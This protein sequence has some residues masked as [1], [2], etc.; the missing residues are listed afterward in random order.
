MTDA[1]GD[2]DDTETGTTA[3]RP[4][5]LDLTRLA[6]LGGD[7]EIS[8]MRLL[9]PCGAVLAEAEPAPKLTS[10]A[11]AERF[12]YGFASVRAG[13]LGEVRL[14]AQLLEQAAGGA[15][16]K[17]AFWKQPDGSLVDG[18]RPGLDPAGLPDLDQATAYRQAHLAA[19]AKLLSEVDRLILPLDRITA[20]RDP[21]DGAL[22]PAPPPGVA[23]PKALKPHRAS[24]E[25][26]DAAFARLHGAVMA[27]RPAGLG[28]WLIVPAPAP[29]A[30]AACRQDRDLL[31]ARAADWAQGFAGVRH[32][33]VL[34]ALTGRLAALPEDHADA[35]RL[36]LLL[37]RLL[38]GEDLLDIASGS[39]AP[40]L[41]TVA[42]TRRERRA[43]DP[44]RKARRKARAK[45]QEGKVM[46]EDE[47]LEAF[48]K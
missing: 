1:R 44:E 45:G 46:C 8:L 35:A 42:P 5:A 10:A 36:G 3:K 26:L 33:P 13:R 27:L 17:H 30:D 39:P 28:L 47:L 18:Q 29:G 4:V 21:A 20:L 40:A 38:A 43:K 11:L 14:L 6:V 31:R 16:P 34:D 41:A 7:A 32:D 48:S 12:G 37:A 15:A 19:V 2:S 25:T 23:C 22:F 24:A 9:R